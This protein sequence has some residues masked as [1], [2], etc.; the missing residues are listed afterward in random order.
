MAQHFFLNVRRAAKRVNQFS[1]VVFRHCIHRQIAAA[2]VV[3]QTNIG[4]GMK[5][6]AAIAAPL[7]FFRSRQC[8]FLAGGRMKKNRKL[9]AD[10][11]ES[12]GRHL[13]GRR[14]DNNKIA[15]AGRTAEQLVAD[16]AADKI[17]LHRCVIAANSS[18][19]P[20]RRQTCESGRPPSGS[21]LP[22]CATRRWGAPWTDSPPP[23]NC[24]N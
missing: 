22:K 3:L 19:R 6:K 2:Q 4:R 5:N 11:L 23:G 1:A 18:A 10:R 17:R 24:R 21:I 16:C 12:G 13:F 14:A 20:R 15:V 9:S 7:L 8:I